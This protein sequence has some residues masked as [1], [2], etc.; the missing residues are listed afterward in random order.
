MQIRVPTQS[1][2]LHFGEIAV[3]VSKNG[4]LT[5]PEIAPGKYKVL[6]DSSNQVIAVATLVSSE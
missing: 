5:I 2:K 1:S 6:D 3:D 4:E